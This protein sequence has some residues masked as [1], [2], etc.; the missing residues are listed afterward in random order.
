LRT[1]GIGPFGSTGIDENVAR[2]ELGLPP[3]PHY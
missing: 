2:A 3:R 1:L